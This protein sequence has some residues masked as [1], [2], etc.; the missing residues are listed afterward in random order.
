M[1][2][3][4]ELWGICIILLREKGQGASDELK[5]RDFRYELEEKEREARD[6]K[7]RDKRSFTG[8]HFL[9]ISFANL[10]LW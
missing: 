7:L 2:I 4:Y 10:H 3:N 5:G 9:A 8:E 6:K 1:L